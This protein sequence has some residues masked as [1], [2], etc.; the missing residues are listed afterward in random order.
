MLADDDNVLSL[1]ECKRQ[2]LRNLQ[3]LERHDYVSKKDGF[4]VLK[5]CPLFVSSELIVIFRPLFHRSAKT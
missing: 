4:Q 2:I 3:I 5:Y 1:E